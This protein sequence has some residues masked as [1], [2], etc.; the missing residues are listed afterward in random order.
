VS[1]ICTGWELNNF[2]NCQLE[3][4]SLNNGQNQI[5]TILRSYWQKAVI[6]LSVSCVN[7]YFLVF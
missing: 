3:T 5:S 6:V 7:R 4:L 2:Y 1:I